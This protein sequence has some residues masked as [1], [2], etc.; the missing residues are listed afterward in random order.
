MKIPNWQYIEEEISNI[1]LK[2]TSKIE[3]SAT[4]NHANAIIDAWQ[5]GKSFEKIISE[6]KPPKKD[7]EN[8]KKAASKI[9]E[10]RELLLQIGYHGS[11]ALEKQS[12]ITANNKLKQK[13]RLCENSYSE[14]LANSLS[15]IS[16]QLKEA[17]NLINASDRG[18]I[19]ALSGAE[20]NPPPERGRK[21]KTTAH[22]IA[23]ICATIFKTGTGNRISITHNPYADTNVAGGKF[24][25]FLTEV[26]KLLE[27]KANAEH[28]IK[29]LL[30][31]ENADLK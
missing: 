26:F 13:Y 7:Q 24:H 5:F 1:I 17:A 19:T 25:T 10:A 16:H 12:Q 6:D 30:T 23:K 2:H 11:T 18:L 29:E 14:I 22:S 27:V 31:E 15:P 21:P 20:T 9:S 4:A 3:C 28:C 8:L